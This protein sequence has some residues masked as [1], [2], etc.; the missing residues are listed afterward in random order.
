MPGHVRPPHPL[1]FSGAI[2]NTNRIFALT[3]IGLLAVGIG[4]CQNKKSPSA[5]SSV[6]DI[7]PQATAAPAPQPYVPPPQP[8]AAQPPAAQPVITDSAA[9]SADGTG[10]ASAGS[11]RVKKGDTLYSIAR[12]RYGNGNQYTKIVA[13]NPGLA[14]EHL[15]V[16]QTINMP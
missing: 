10:A 13:A 3:V 15:K 12:A 1:D 14:P 4:G 5:N 6:T 16:G 2:V 8:V 9:P 7:S 11:Y